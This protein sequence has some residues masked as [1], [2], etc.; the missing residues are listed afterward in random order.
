MDLRRCLLEGEKEILFHN[1]G[2]ELV[3]SVE[4]REYDPNTGRFSAN[5]KDKYGDFDIVGT[6]DDEK[7][8]FQ[9]LYENYKVNS[10]CNPIRKNFSYKGLCSEDSRGLNFSGEWKEITGVMPDWGK[11]EMFLN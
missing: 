3:S 8:D 1:E 4:F 2:Q 9:K 11:W 5:G 10:Y 7:V 6:I